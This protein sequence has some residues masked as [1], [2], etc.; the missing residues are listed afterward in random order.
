MG[1]R[2][3]LFLIFFLVGED[4]ES[5]VAARSGVA[6]AAEKGEDEGPYAASQLLG[7][8]SGLEWC[9][10][11]SG[12]NAG[13]ASFRLC[14]TKA[15]ERKKTTRGRGREHLPT[16]QAI[17]RDG[18]VGLWLRQH[19][20][21]IGIL[22]CLLWQQVGRD[23]IQWP[24]PEQRQGQWM[25]NGPGVARWSSITTS[26]D[27]TVMEDEVPQAQEWAQEHWT[28]SRPGANQGQGNWEQ[29][30]KQRGHYNYSSRPCFPNYQNL[31]RGKDCRL[32]PE[33]RRTPKHCQQP[34]EIARHWTSC[35]RR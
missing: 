7:G 4:Y 6:Q 19:Q 13:A 23:D 15:G 24:S 30:R 9:N 29:G 8:L 21:G 32:Q 31:L 14:T 2:S 1:R 5:Q 12:E 18:S 17:R 34:Q 20:Q 27:Y 28:G 3:L 11:Q 16:G 10:G 22:L 25:A 26:L 35:Y 33:H